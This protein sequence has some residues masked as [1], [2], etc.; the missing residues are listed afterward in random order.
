[1]HLMKK[2]PYIEIRPAFFPLHKMGI[3]VQSAKACPNSEDVYDSLFCVPSSALLT[4][5]D[6]KEVCEAVKE[7]FVEVLGIPKI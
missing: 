5:D 2:H 3:F 7:A 1:M 6:V 4:H